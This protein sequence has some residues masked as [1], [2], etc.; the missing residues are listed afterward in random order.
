MKSLKNL[1]SIQIIVLSFAACNGNPYEM[2]M[3]GKLFSLKFYLLFHPK[4][5]NLNDDKGLNLIHYS[6]LGNK[7]YICEYLI[8]KGGPLEGKDR[9]GDTPLHLASQKGYTEI[10]DLL[11]T[12]GASP[13]NQ[14]NDGDTPL[15]LSSKN[16]YVNISKLLLSK[17][18]DPNIRNNYLDTPLFLVAQNGNIEITKLLL[19]KGSQVNAMNLDLS[20][21]RV[22]I[23]LQQKNITDDNFIFREFQDL[24]REMDLDEDRYKDLTSLQKQAKR[25]EFR[26]KYEREYMGHYFLIYNCRVNNV[27]KSFFGS[28]V[29]IATEADAG[30]NIDVYI[31]PSDEKSVFS[32]KAGDYVSAIGKFEFWGTGIL[33]NHALKQAFIIERPGKTPLDIAI[34]NGHNDIAD[35]IRGKGGIE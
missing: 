32:L 8:D 7:K 18:A 35:L 12:K 29:Y 34:E 24:I 13:N 11:I 9:N 3:G 5:I 33:F 14:N 27:D 26:K 21:L 31:E 16:K 15:H 10:C 2:A 17:G 22:K 28:Q 1:I 4:D 23:V 6:V 20:W 19:S 30:N 25:E